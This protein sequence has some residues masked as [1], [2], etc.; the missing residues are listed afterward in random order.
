MGQLTALDQQR[1][2]NLQQ[3]IAACDELKQ[4]FS[5]LDDLV[6]RFKV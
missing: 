4:Q 1:A 2:E 5:S 3:T 6:H